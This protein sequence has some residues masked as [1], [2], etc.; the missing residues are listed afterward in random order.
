[1][2]RNYI[3][4]AFRNIWRNKVYSTINILGLAV[5]IASCLLILLYIQ[6]EYGFDRFH[7]DSDRIYRVFQQFGED[8]SKRMTSSGGQMGPAMVKD[9]PE[10][11]SYVRMHRKTSM[12]QTEL[13]G[14]M[15]I[16]E[17]KQ[18]AFVDSQFFQFFN[19]DLLVGNPSKVL[20]QPFQLV[21]S[22]S[23]AKK[24]FGNIDPIGKTLTIDKRFSY[25]ISGIMEDMPS[26]SHFRY[27][28]VAP[29]SSMMQFYGIDDFYSWWWPA[30]YT[31]VKASPEADLSTISENRLNTF[32]RNYR[33]ADNE[34][35]PRLQALTDVR[36]HGLYG[37]DGS[38]A[39]VYMFLSIAFVV[40]LI[41]CMNFMNL[42]TARSAARATEVGIRKVVGARRR[43]LVSQFLGESL[44]ITA[45][46]IVL[47]LAIAE[48][49]LPVF[50]SLAGLDLY[51]SWSNAYL[52]LSI[53]GILIGVGLMA[54]SYPALYLSS[55][56]PLK[57]L[58]SGSGNPQGGKKMREGLV[59]LQFVISVSLIICTIMIYRQHQFMLNKSLGYDHSQL[60]SIKLSESAVK[61]KYP[62][63]KTSLLSI[64]QIKQV[65][66]S[67]WTPGDNNVYDIP[68]YL[69]QDNGEMK[70]LDERGILYVGHD[71]F[72]T[73]GLEL[74]D[75]RW[76]SPE[77]TADSSY[78]YVVNKE[79]LKY[80]G[81]GPYLDRKV[82]ISYG[83]YGQTL[84]EKPGKIV[85]VIE[86]FHSVDLRTPIRPYLITLATKTEIN[87]I[88]ATCLV[89]L[90]PGD[91]QA[92]L[93]QIRNNW[94]ELFGELPLEIS[95]PNEKIAAAYQHE[96]QLG[97]ILASFAILAIFIACLGLLGLAAFTAQQRTKEIGIRKVLGASAP[98]IMLLLNRRFTLL[99]LI[100]LLVSF[101]LA[102]YLIDL[103][104][105]DYPYQVGFSLWPFVLAG[106]SALMIT[107]L[108][109]GFQSLKA[110]LIDP[111][112]ALRY[113]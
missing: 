46:S 60:L 93:T 37:D 74:V 109:V 83:E 86:D 51:I 36:F 89:R 108:T 14:E 24:Y 112:L 47:G 98:N 96:S 38:A 62:A 44:V 87:E 104:M 21:I 42:A 113:E 12:V 67:S 68:A 100:S 101:P 106:L 85:G 63:L 61:Q 2:I 70:F 95:F 26:Q 82:S 10:I 92:T 110:A 33:E 27:G 102:Y 25:T 48:L 99:V 75:G 59:V 40:L 81:E 79:A 73:L 54:G 94:E 80:M 57:V 5:G 72:E 58:K 69:E 84:Y 76:F 55:F 20:T 56:I 71:F 30:T 49:L 88:F 11:E 13:D 39:Y 97:N 7:R 90:E 66:A 43:N 3:K 1:M 64:P 111:V 6:F 107:W 23:A 52:W 29:I 4:I 77:Y 53:M 45:I 65:S 18:F 19:F 22:Q 41:A 34:V 32:I 9:F 28:L 91:V 50:N 31:M 78:A 16:F 105:E 103:W 8:N 15:R 17:E 35:V